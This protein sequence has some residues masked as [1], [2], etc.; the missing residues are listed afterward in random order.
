VEEAAYLAIASL[1][2][3]WAP[4]PVALTAARDGERLVIDLRAP[5]PP[6]A[7]VVHIEDRVGALGGSIAVSPSASAGTRV[8]VELPCA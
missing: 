7:D 6:P 4:Q 3:E 5:A 8:T 2:D 1:A